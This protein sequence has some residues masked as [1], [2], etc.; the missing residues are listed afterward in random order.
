MFWIR[1]VAGAATA[2]TLKPSRVLSGGFAQHEA[3]RKRDG[4]MSSDYRARGSENM[5]TLG[6]TNNLTVQ[7]SGLI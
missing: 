3:T 4:A 6:R 2:L 7:C 5:N 1:S